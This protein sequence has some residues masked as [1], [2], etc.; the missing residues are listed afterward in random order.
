MLK[1]LIISISAVSIALNFVLSYFLVDQAISL[2]HGRS[3]YADCE[4]HRDWLWKM[5]E[6]KPLNPAKDAE[7]FWRHGDYVRRVDHDEIVVH[8]D[9]SGRLLGSAFGASQCGTQ[10]DDQ[11]DDP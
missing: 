9:E 8:R 4:V 11:W 7:L 10:G 1:A 3:G 6:G 2:D 5:V